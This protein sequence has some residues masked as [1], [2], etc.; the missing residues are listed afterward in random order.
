MN[1]SYSI[2]GGANWMGIFGTGSK[3][4]RIEARI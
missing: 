3:C 4:E 2:Q 1:Y